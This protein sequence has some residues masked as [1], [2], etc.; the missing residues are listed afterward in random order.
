M[1][2]KLGILLATI[3]LTVTWASVW[4]MFEKAGQPWWAALV[5]GY[6]FAVFCRVGG[7]PGWWWVWLFVPGANL[8]AA[9]LAT[10]GVARRFGYG[11]RMTV[12]LLL[13]PFVGYPVLGFG[14]CRYQPPEKAH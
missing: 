1:H 11:A 7:K 5:P 14:N 12:V 4:K 2:H 6:G 8:A 3:L 10:H 13:L 9:V